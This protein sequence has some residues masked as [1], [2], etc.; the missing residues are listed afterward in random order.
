MRSVG[1]SIAL[2]RALAGLVGEPVGVLDDHDLPAP[3]DRGE[4]RAADQVAHLVDADRELLGADDGDVGVAAGQH[5]VARV[6]LAAAGRLLLALQG[7]G[8]GDRG[9]GAARARAAR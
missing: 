5:G 3:A 8:E 9:V 2:S 4:R 7:G 6:A 1:S